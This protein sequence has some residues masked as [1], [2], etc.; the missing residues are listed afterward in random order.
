LLF[1]PASPLIDIESDGDNNDVDCVVDS[2][3]LGFMKDIIV[4]PPRKVKSPVN[5]DVVL[6]TVKRNLAEAFDGVSKAEHRKSLRRV[7]IEKE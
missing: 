1:Q 5:E 4:S 7:K 2:Q 3:P 6:N